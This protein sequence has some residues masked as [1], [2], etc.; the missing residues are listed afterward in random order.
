LAV[1]HCNKEGASLGSATQNPNRKKEEW[2]EAN[3]SV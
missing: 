2:P 1:F 3:Y